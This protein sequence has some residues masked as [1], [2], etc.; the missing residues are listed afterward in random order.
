MPY[1]GRKPPTESARTA[2]EIAAEFSAASGPMTVG[3]AFSRAMGR[4][5]THSKVRE[6]M[7][8]AA[9]HKN[10]MEQRRLLRVAH[11]H[12]EEWLNKR[13]GG[14]AEAEGRRADSTRSLMSSLDWYEQE[15]RKHDPSGMVGASQLNKLGSGAVNT[16]H[17]TTFAGGGSEYAK[18]SQSGGYTARDRNWVFKAEGEPEEG[19]GAHPPLAELGEVRLENT[20]MVERNVLVA[21]VAEGMGTTVIPETRKAIHDGVAGSAMG[22]A[23]GKAPLYYEREH[24]NSETAAA[25][26]DMAGAEDMGYKRDARGWYQDKPKVRAHDYEGATS[27]S[28]RSVVAR[29]QRDLLDLQAV[30]FVTNA[31]VDRHQGNYHYDP[32]TGGVQGIDNDYS[33]GTRV[34]HAENHSKM[35]GLPPMLHAST[36]AR[37]SGMGSEAFA[38]S[39]ENLSEAEKDAAMQRFDVMKQH[40]NKLKEEGGIRGGLRLKD[41]AQREDALDLNFAERRKLFE[42]RAGFDAATY[43]HLTN[44]EASPSYLKSLHADTQDPRLRGVRYNDKTE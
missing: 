7:S 37:I 4:T 15:H 35:R 2:R 20:S 13:K 23:P 18:D 38:K 24:V 12:A 42:T 41:G 28:G 43:R 29:T 25:L 44:P 32:K 34:E 21:K 26:D 10:P 31:G 30:D 5:S 33:F 39:V 8:A 16:V 1:D 3:A 27:P 17:T 40:V 11:S 9:K 36:A 19:P 6:A 22:L 14:G